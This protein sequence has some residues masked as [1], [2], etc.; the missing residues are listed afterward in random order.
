MNKAYFATAEKTL[1]NSKGFTLIELM[2]TV[3]I[4]AILAAIAV[5]SYQHFIKKNDIQKVKS[6]IMMQ[7]NELNKWRAR[8]LNYAG[9]ASQSQTFD[10]D[11]KTF[12][13]PDTGSAKYDIKMVTILGSGSNLSES[14]FANASV[15]TNYVILATPLLSGYPYIGFS[16]QGIQCESLD[17]SITAIKIFKD[18]NCGT[19]SS[20]W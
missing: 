18:S 10:S 4:I 14:T 5:P 3:M 11:K 7:S 17:S 20:L 12:H 9:F 13:Y 19:G 6:I 15:A 2:I 1:L 8:Q 16:S